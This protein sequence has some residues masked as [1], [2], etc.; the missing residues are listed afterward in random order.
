MSV[1]TN[2][3]TLYA[4]ASNG[5]TKQW[6]IRVEIDDV[7]GIA[8][9]IMESGY[10]DGKIA[11][12]ERKI[13]E[14]KNIGRSNE[15]TV[16]DQAIADAQSKYNKKLDEAYSPDVTALKDLTVKLPMLAL[17]YEKRKHN[18]EFP[19]F[20]QPKLDG[21][22]CIAE[23]K[24][25]A[26]TYTSRKEKPFTTLA[27]LTDDILPMAKG[28][29][30]PLDGEI[31]VHEEMTFQEVTSAIKKLGDNTPKLKYCIYDIMD[32]NLTFAERN[33][34]LVSAFDKDYPTLE[35][36]PTY[37]AANEEEIKKYHE[38][39]VSE[40]YEGVIIRN[41]DGKYKIKHR[42]KDLQKWKYFMDD[43][44]EII[45][46]KEA[47]GGDA[48]TVIFRCKTATGGEFDV[49]P[50]GSRETRRRWFDELD[51]IK[52]CMLTV[53]YQNLSDDGIPRFPV[54][55]SIRDYE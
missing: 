13:T 29:L 53:R 47:T 14:G 54:G 16:E 1:L 32:E 50:R 4:K 5:K 44:Y 34:L 20:V 37:E 41:K 38:Q 21:V 24:D 18:I 30:A 46:G 36:V 45:G 40:G 7:I 12:N 43:E 31:Y 2:F 8:T 35:L 51:S 49:R 33:E 15:T 27:H 26:V 28:I 3:P 39:F 19:C 48:G 11:V 23:I 10:T 22:R 17:G 9:I 52:G 55:I 6:A 25:M 42:S